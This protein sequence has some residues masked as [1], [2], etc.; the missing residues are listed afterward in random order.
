S[1]GNKL[2]EQKLTFTVYAYN[3]T[4]LTSPK[5]TCSVNITPAANPGTGAGG[6]ITTSLPADNYVVEMVMGD[7]VATVGYYRADVETPVVTITIAGTGFTT[8]GGWFT[9]PNL[10]SRSNFGFTVKYL[11]NGN[12]QGNSLY[13]YRK[14]V[15][16]NSIANPAGGYLPAGAYNWIIKS[17]AMQGLNQYCNAATPQTCYAQFTGKSTITAVNRST[18]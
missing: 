15:A 9:E 16:A 13:I 1:L 4:L 17:N 11:K 5:F 6:C 10:L 12:I 2:G 14:T 8:G 3:D 18:G 7:K